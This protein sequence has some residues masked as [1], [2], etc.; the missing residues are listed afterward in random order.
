[1]A[2]PDE[3]NRMELTGALPLALKRGAT[4]NKVAGS[5][6]GEPGGESLI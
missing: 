5:A 1:V 3:I 6:S 2:R 4:Q